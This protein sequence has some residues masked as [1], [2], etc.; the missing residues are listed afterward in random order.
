V[1]RISA[2]MAQIAKMPEVIQ[3]LNNAGID[4]I[5]SNPA[6]YNKA[7]LGENERLT[8]AI[9]AAGIKSE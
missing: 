4:S 3:I 5:G 9:A 6:D 1:E 2:E 8:K 7:I